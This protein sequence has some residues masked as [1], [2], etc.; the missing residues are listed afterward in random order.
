MKTTDITC[1]E[2]GA[3]TNERCSD[4]GVFVHESAFQAPTKVRLIDA[5]QIPDGRRAALK[6]AAKLIDSL[7]TEKRRGS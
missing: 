4:A 7:P 1:V 6:N 5:L 2:C 3:K